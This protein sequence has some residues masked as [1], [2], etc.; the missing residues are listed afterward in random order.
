MLVS[1]FVVTFVF[2]FLPLAV[3]A[4]LKDWVV[5]GVVAVVCC[6]FFAVGLS[7]AFANR[8]RICQILTNHTLAVTV[9]Q[10]VT[11]IL[12]WDFWLKQY[13]TNAFSRIYDESY[14][15]SAWIPIS[16]IVFVG[17]ILA[18]QFYAIHTKNNRFRT[19]N[20]RGEPV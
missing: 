11:L 20:R 9:F 15:V 16:I 17:L 19:S 4:I 10:V 2:C 7:K 6:Y 12:R 1:N 14:D 3:S 8:F 13:R 5:L 18:A